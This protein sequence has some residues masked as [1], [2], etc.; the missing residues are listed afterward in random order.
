MSCYF[1]GPPI[2]ICLTRYFFR[3]K[4][5][6]HFTRWRHP[7]ITNYLARSDIFLAS[8]WVKIISCH[9]DGA[10]QFSVLTPQHSAN[11]MIDSSDLTHGRAPPFPWT[12]ILNSVIKRSSVLENYSLNPWQE[13]GLRPMVCIFYLPPCS[14]SGE[15]P[16]TGWLHHGPSLG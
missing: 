1:T 10:G 3:Q 2:L 14:L 8:V 11:N 5:H 7:G 13:S 4:S 15:A 9:R 16:C 12:L 6:I